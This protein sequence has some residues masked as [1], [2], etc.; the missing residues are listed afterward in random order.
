MDNKS[1]LNGALR[2][3]YVVV[4][5]ILVVFVAASMSAKRQAPTT[6]GSSTITVST[7]SRSEAPAQTSILQPA[8]TENLR[9]ATATVQSWISNPGVVSRALKSAGQSVPENI[10]DLTGA[11]NIVIANPASAVLMVEY[12]NADQTVV[13]DVLS[14]LSSEVQKEQVQYN[15]GVAD[16][17]EIRASMTDPVLTKVVAREGLVSAL[18]ILVGLLLGLVFV[19]LLSRGK[20]GADQSRG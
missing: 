18:S 15:L 2:Y 14:A 4:V 3:W 13:Q 16:Q 17:P 7:V 12:A 5:C 9:I 1:L 10:D 19:A 20:E 6:L 8:P 11:F